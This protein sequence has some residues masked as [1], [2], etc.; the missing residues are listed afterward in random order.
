MQFTYKLKIRKNT[1]KNNVQVGFLKHQLTWL[2]LSPAL[3][4]HGLI[5]VCSRELEE[6]LHCLNHC[7]Q[8][9][10][11]LV[12]Q[13]LPVLEARACAAAGQSGLMALYEA[14]FTQYSTCT[15]QVLLFSSLL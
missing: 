9:R 6:C 13:S 8:T 1:I 11:A 4:W 10:S 7:N 12:L 2:H 3:A 15:A 5:A 14:M